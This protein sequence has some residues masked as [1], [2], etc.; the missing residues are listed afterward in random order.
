[1]KNPIILALWGLLA[2]VSAHT[3]FVQLGSAG[4]TYR[5]SSSF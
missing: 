2:A 1:M 4:T 5:K 3:T